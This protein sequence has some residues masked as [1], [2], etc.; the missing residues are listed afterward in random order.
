MIISDT[1]VEKKK[2]DKIFPWNLVNSQ[3][4]IDRE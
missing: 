2:A 3:C 1:R 4:E